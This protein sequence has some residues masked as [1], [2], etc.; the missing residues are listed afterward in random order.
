MGLAVEELRDHVCLRIIGQL[1]P[2]LEMLDILFSV[3]CKRQ[4]HTFWLLGMITSVQV[5]N[6]LAHPV[7]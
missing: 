4:S 5:F 2:N 3:C 7:I 1:S 6:S